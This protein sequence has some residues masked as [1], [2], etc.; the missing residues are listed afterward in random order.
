MTAWL[1][2][3]TAER[4]ALLRPLASQGLSYSGMVAVLSKTYGEINR[5]SVIGLCQRGG[6]AVARGKNGWT[7]PEDALPEVAVDE[8]TWRLLPPEAKTAAVRK[9]AAQGLSAGQIAGQLSL[10]H[11]RV[12]RGAVI[13]VVS[14]AKIRLH[15]SDPRRAPEKISARA[16][17]AKPGLTLVAPVADASA[18]TEA[19]AAPVTAPEAPA[20]PA[21]EL[22]PEEA[23]PVPLLDL[24]P[25]SC[26]YPVSHDPRGIASLFC[27][28]PVSRGSY[29]ACH[30]LR[31]YTTAAAL[32]AEMQPR[33]MPLRRGEINIRRTA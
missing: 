13:G 4:Q 21:P 1:D 9:L 20:R 30:A 25:R 18:E 19:V 16:R 24:A 7:V 5:R 27:G 17:A 12:S 31:V 2:L 3:S 26:R 29:C 22:L 14:R 28:A 6:I 8:L 10:K 15:A 33:A 23:R 11:G 32:K